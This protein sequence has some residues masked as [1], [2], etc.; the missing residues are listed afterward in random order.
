MA[1]LQSVISVP[2][3]QRDLKAHKL[4]HALVS[5]MVPAAPKH[6]SPRQISAQV[7]KVARPVVEWI[8]RVETGDA[9]YVKRGFAIRMRIFDNEE[10]REKPSPGRHFPGKASQTKPNMIHR[11][12]SE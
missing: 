12:M 8:F 5:G 2:E 4:N 7:W 10:G 3:R 11:Q 6:C 9:P 1:S